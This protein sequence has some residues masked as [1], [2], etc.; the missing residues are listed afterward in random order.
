MRIFLLILHGLLLGGCFTTR[1]EAPQGNNKVRIMAEN[2]RATFHKEYKDWYLLSGLLPIW[3][4]DIAE[5]ITK[6]RLT[7][8]RVQTEDRVSDGIITLLTEELLLGLYP[9][10]IVIEGNTV[11]PGSIIIEDTTKRLTHSQPRP[12]RNQP[13][14]SPSAKTGSPTSGIPLTPSPKSLGLP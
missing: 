10:S 2:E 11:S 8:V 7:E 5:L 6:E 3:R 13:L 9:Q 12:D 4:T 14:T 1:L